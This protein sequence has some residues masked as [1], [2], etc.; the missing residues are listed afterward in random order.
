[1]KICYAINQVQMDLICFLHVL[2]FLN[3]LDGKF[4]HFVLRPAKLIMYLS[5]RLYD[6]KYY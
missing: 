3:P 2:F 6:D 4:E 1:M 5:T